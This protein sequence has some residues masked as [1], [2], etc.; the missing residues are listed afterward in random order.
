MSSKIVCSTLR[1]C[2]ID[3]RLKR[4]AYCQ[5]Y[6]VASSPFVRTCSATVFDVCHWS[7][8]SSV[9]DGTANYFALPAAS[10]AIIIADASISEYWPA[11]VP[12]LLLFVLQ[13]A[14]YSLLLTHD[15]LRASAACVIAFRS[16]SVCHVQTTVHGVKMTQ[17]IIKL[18]LSHGSWQLYHYGFLSTKILANFDWVT[19][20]INVQM[21]CRT[22]D[23]FYQHLAILW[24]WYKIVTWF[25]WNANRKS[26]AVCRTIADDPPWHLKLFWT[27]LGSVY[28]FA[29]E[30]IV[31]AIERDAWAIVCT[32]ALKRKE[33]SSHSPSRTLAPNCS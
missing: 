10:L 7:F 5:Q 19:L 15:A 2:A 16:I 14:V 18:S 17:Y 25:I 30:T 28:S 20:I 3:F 4:S 8:L 1:E 31:T 12:S 27:S 13:S 26:N 6:V 32:V 33:W 11:T 9:R 21:W 22:W 29:Y 23:F 24:M